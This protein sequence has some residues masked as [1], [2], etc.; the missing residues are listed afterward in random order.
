M[1]TSYIV[2]AQK[3]IE[4]FVSELGDISTVDK[5]WELMNG[6]NRFN[7]KH[8][9]KVRYDSGLSR[10]CLITSDYVVKWDKKTRYIRT[11]GGCE[12]EYRAYLTADEDG[13]SYLLAD[14]TKVN[15]SGKD[16]Y[17]MPRVYKI[18]N[19]GGCLGNFLSE[20]EVDWINEHFE[21]M[22]D[23]NWGFLNGAVKIIDYAWT[24]EGEEEE[25]EPA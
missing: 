22:H 10:H 11:I 3:F 16:F 21:D 18:N 24:I 20:D 7:T 5:V 17:I 2:R 23:G 25:E 14:I 19:Q 4:Q 15:V 6:I 9:R 8:K 1:K 13:M 12:R